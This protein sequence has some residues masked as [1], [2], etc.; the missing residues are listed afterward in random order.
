MSLLVLR[1]AWAL[2]RESLQELLEGAPRSLDVNR[3]IR[4]LTLNIA[5]VR[6]VHHVHLWQVGEKPLLTLHAQVIPPYDHD[7]L[8]HRIHDY[9]RQH[10]Q[11]A[12]ATVQMEYQPCAGAECE[13][14][15]SGAAATGHDHSHSHDHEHAHAKGEVHTH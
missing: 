15:L 8:L 13:L 4:D 14:G 6:N 10:Y 5:E 11:I 9:L 7:A 2:L 3:L 12:H 1:S